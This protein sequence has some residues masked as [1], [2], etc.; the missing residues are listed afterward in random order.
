MPVVLAQALPFDL[1]W[2][3][4]T[5]LNIGIQVALCVVAFFYGHM[6]EWTMHRYL[7]HGHGKKKGSPFGFHWKEHHRACRKHEFVDPDYLKEGF[8]LEG[9]KFRENFGVSAMILFHLPIAIISPLAFI[10]I[11]IH[12]MRYMHLHTKMHLDVEWC[13]EHRAYHYDHHMAP[14]QDTNWM[15]TGAWFDRLMGTHE[16]WLHAKKGADRDKQNA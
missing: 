1:W 13:K 16:P 5:P 9:P 7:F 2:A 10:V 8:R 12:G 15:V 14:N 4:P 11:A 6:V 3:Q